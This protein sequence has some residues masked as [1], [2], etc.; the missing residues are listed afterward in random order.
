MDASLQEQIQQLPG[1]PGVY[2]FFDIE[3]TFLYIG[4]AKNLKKR[5]S[6]YFSKQ[7]NG[8]TR[9]LVKKIHSIEYTLVETEMDALLLENSLIKKHQPRYNINLKDD[10]SYPYLKIVNER[11][12]RIISTRR[13]YKDGSTYLGPYSS[14]KTQKAV[15]EFLHNTFPLRTCKYNLSEENI[16]K[17]KF[18]ACLEYHL[19]KCNAPCE[20]KEKEETYEEYIS[21]AKN[22]LTGKA[23][24]VKRF[25]KEKMAFFAA[26][27]NFEEAE[28]YK[29]KIELVDV[30]QSKSTIVNERIKDLDV[31]TITSKDNM[32]AVNYLKV[33]S[34]TVSS[35]KSIILKNEIDETEEDK[36]IYALI[37]LRNE[38]E[39]EASEICTNIDFELE[40]A[41]FSIA[42]PLQGDKL[43]LV[44]LSVRN[45][46]TFLK[47]KVGL[48][49]KVNRKNTGMT[50]LEQAKHDLYLKEIPF[51]IECF[52][53]SNIQGTTPVASMV[54]FKNSLP[55]KKE[56]RHFNIKTVVGAD[57]FA[58][59][60]EIVYRRYKRLLEEKAPLPQLVVIDGGKGQLGKAVEALTDLGLM[61]KLTVISIAKRLEEI[62][63][64]GD[65]LPLMLSKKS[66]TLK[67]L[68]RLRNEAHRFAI[69]F[70]RLKRDKVSG[71]ELEQIDGI[72]RD[73]ATKL[74][75]AFKTI[76]G[77]L[78]N[79]TAV[80]KLI[81]PAKT[82]LVFDYFQHK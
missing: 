54:C 46:E 24:A 11:F 47:E 62:F 44:K 79:E 81:G 72:G 48:K 33:I 55:S 20:G 8:K 66:T 56:Y 17:K 9:V 43:K 1:K 35:T 34:G 19:G 25:M 73:T 14:V 80:S 75:S 36:L 2:R 41:Q 71:S 77:V 58:S 68:Q 27:L 63:Y 7:Y 22:V 13:K 60:Y 16:E 28:R 65:E 5:V 10:K 12:P 59:M 6:S 38:F 69:T 29:R 50:I 37:E 61:S 32:S 23:S 42:M 18:K 52:D 53:N 31:F 30:Y 76:K 64:P 3:K 51:H 57:D 82:K 39:S 40:T 67:L 70:H 45:A 78:D 26:N 15:L 49:D 21:S 74:L 4:K